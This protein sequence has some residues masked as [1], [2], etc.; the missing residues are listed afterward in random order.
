MTPSLMLTHF[1]AA[2]PPNLERCHGNGP[3]RKW[4]LSTKRLS[5]ACVFLQYKRGDCLAKIARIYPLL[6]LTCGI[7]MDGT[8]YLTTHLYLQL[9]DFSLSLVFMITLLCT[10]RDF[11]VCYDCEMS[12]RGAFTAISGQ[13]PYTTFGNAVSLSITLFGLSGFETVLLVILTL[14]LSSAR[15][16]VCHW[17]RKHNIA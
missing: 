12:A 3:K 16:S 8:V 5:V 6:W 4:K 9:G 11:L 14:G 15:T 7:N 17:G 13:I 1:W 2:V 10:L